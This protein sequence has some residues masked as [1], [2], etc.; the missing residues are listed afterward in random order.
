MKKFLNIVLALCSLL[1]F[2]LQAQT[3]AKPRLA[4]VDF[5]IKV[6]QAQKALGTAM[7]DLLIDALVETRRYFIVERSVL[8]ALRQEQIM[9]LSGEVDA[10]TGAEVGKL[11]GAE[12]LVVG[13]VS[14]FQENTGGGG[15][16]SIVGGKALG[17]IGWYTSELGITVRIIQAT[18]GEIVVSEKINQKE[19]SIGLIAAAA[20][21]T[22]AAGGSLYKSKS[23]QTA[24]EKAIVKAVDVI[25]EQI[26]GSDGQEEIAAGD[27]TGA[28]TIDITAKNL[29]FA[30]SRLFAKSLE[31]VDGVKNVKSAFEGKTANLKVKYQGAA[32]NFA[33]ALLAAEMPGFKLKIESLAPKKIVMKI[34]K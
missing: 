26:P 15:L 7:S 27:S 24:M 12:Y 22:G 31:K 18:T 25:G 10:A 1:H 9:A 28:T 29:D 4:V 11:V 3:K 17:G 2:S 32:E 30:T 5:Q 16:G 19:S 6:E 20:T 34:E 13:V 21:T 14:K 23:M 8:Q 33:D